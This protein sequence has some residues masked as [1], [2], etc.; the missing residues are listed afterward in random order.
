VAYHM[1]RYSDSSSDRFLWVAL[2]EI[3]NMLEERHGPIAV[4]S[5]PITGGRFHL[6][7]QGAEGDELSVLGGV[8]K[9]ANDPRAKW[10][11]KYYGDE[12][13]KP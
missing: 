8:S 5:H 10:E 9:M 11:A 4:T 1:T 13:A 7:S 12:N 2:E 3:L 6:I